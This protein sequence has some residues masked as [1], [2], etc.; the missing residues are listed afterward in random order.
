MTSLGET[1]AS[2]HWE[3]FIKSQIDTGRYSSASEVVRDALRHMEEC[4][5]RAKQDLMNIG[6][7][8]LKMWGHQQRNISLKAIFKRFDLISDYGYLI[9]V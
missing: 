5:P 2:G 3:A 7:Y 4:T 6:R 1:N 9:D 8:T